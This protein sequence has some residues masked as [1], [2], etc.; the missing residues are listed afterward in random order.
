MAED[1]GDGGREPLDCWCSSARAAP[2]ASSTEEMGS[3]T[4]VVLVVVVVV[5]VTDVEGVD[6]VG[7]KLF[8]SAKLL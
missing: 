6:V 7:V 1:E 3:A 8:A 2:L 4:T 5:E